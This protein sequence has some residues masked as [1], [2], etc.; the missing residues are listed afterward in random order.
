MLWNNANMI[1][2]TFLIIFIV[3]FYFKEKKP[4]ILLM[5]PP[6]LGALFFQTSLANNISK[7]IRISLIAVLGLMMTVI[8]FILIRDAKAS[9]EK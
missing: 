5:L 6:A 8:F 2:F 4:Y 9:K 1:L 7:P 3:V